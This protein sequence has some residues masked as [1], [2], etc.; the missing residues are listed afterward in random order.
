[1]SPQRFVQ[2][3]GEREQNEKHEKH[4]TQKKKKKKKKQTRAPRT[5]PWA[6]VQRQPQEPPKHIAGREFLV[7]AQISHVTVG[8]HFSGIPGASIE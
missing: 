3:Q 4:E 1:M 7:P 5:D 8:Y 6:L 2:L